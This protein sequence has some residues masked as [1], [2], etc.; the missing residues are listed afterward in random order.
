MLG[1]TNED[2]IRTIEER[3]KIKYKYIKA[4][5]FNEDVED[6]EL[7]AASIM[8]QLEATL[9]L[10]KQEEAEET[11]EAFKVA[12]GVSEALTDFKADKVTQEALK[13]F[14][15]YHIQIQM[16]SDTLKAR[17]TVTY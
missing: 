8:E 13:S 15:G 3:K 1:D 17:W 2:E 10:A 12:D 5:A 4:K 6:I 11:S 14:L 16:P 7:C 9:S